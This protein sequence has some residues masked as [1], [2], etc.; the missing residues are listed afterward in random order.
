MTVWVLG[1]QWGLV[2]HRIVRVR[3]GAAERVQIG[4]GAMLDA[5]GWA[6]GRDFNVS[7]VYFRSGSLGQFVSFGDD[8]T[9]VQRWVDLGEY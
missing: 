6:D 2:W 4:C 8:H 9:R 5:F 3:Y 7:T 1:E